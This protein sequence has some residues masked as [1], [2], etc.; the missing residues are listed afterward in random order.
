MTTIT[1]YDLRDYVDETLALDG[2]TLL[3]QGD[4]AALCGKLK[5]R[6]TSIRARVT[7]LIAELEEEREKV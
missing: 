5:F 1:L 7:T 2:E 6:L 4:Y 3:T